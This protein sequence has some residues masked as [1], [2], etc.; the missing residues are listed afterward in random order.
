MSLL[1]MV[2]LPVL[3]ARFRGVLAEWMQSARADTEG[4]RYAAWV[5]VW[6][7]WVVWG[8]VMVGAVYKPEWNGGTDL[9]FVFLHVVLVGCN[10]LVHRRLAGGKRVTWLWVL[11]LSITDF[12]MITASIMW[13]PGLDNF[14]YLAYYPALAMVAVICPSVV[15]SLGWTTV[16]A[17]FYVL[18]CLTQGPGLDFGANDGVAVLI[19]RMAA[20][21]GVVV[22]FNVVAGE[23]TGR[24]RSA[25]RERVLLQERVELS[26]AIHDR[27]AQSAYVLGLGIDTARLVA[28]QSNE[29]LSETLAAASTVSKSLI[30]ELRQ[31]IDG[32]LIFGGAYL[33]Q[34]LA[35]HAETFGSIARV[36]VEMVQLGDEPPLPVE[37]RS[38]LFAVAHNALANA[39]LHS[40]AD[41]VE[42]TLDFRGDLVLMSVSDNGV[43]LPDDYAERGR[44]FAGMRADANRMGG[45]LIVG[46]AGP[47]GGTAVMCEVP[48]GPGFGGNGH[49]QG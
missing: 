2:E 5:S 40:R 9:P 11:A 27:A 3:K 14:H 28:G 1:K 18:W 20:M 48:L 44:G 32:G 45:R 16:V 21:Y 22:A 15:L 30:W 7:R 8:A 39:M 47:E 25:E 12:V 42:V 49:A 17:A 37:V 24:R 29:E 33:G 46:P 6:G 23:R 4:A 34:T 26:Q 13:D 19:T 38:R 10:A 41:L 43:G 35:V 36:S 31:P